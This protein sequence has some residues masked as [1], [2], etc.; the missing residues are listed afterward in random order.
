MKAKLI[1]G[2][3]CWLWPF[4]C[5]CPHSVA[6]LSHGSEANSKRLQKT[7][8]IVDDLTF[9]VIFTVHAKWHLGG[10]VN[11]HNVAS[12]FIIWIDVNWCN[13]SRWWCSSRF[14]PSSTVLWGRLLWQDEFSWWWRLRLMTLFEPHDKNCQARRRKIQMNNS[15]AEEIQFSV[16]WILRRRNFT[17]RLA[18]GRV[19]CSR[20]IIFYDMRL[21]WK[22]F[23]SWIWCKARR[24]WKFLGLAM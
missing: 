10:K 15:G 1:S 18:F 12:L 20:K 23:F 16:R 22:V 17:A 3:W 5:R 24:E 19:L 9:D 13:S 11:F 14:S 2:N 6:L 4:L 7:T 21:N 8:K